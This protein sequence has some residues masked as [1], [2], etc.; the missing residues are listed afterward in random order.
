MN[1]RQMPPTESQNREYVA[2][3]NRHFNFHAQHP[4]AQIIRQQ[5]MS[6]REPT[7]TYIPHEEKF[8][9]G[10]ISG[11]AYLPAPVGDFG[12]GNRPGVILIAGGHGFF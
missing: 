5:S 4:D 10:P 1:I 9:C 12:D 8:K 6:L 7:A 2:Q 11:I 3:I